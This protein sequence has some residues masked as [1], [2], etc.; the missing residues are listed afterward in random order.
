M[1]E[2]Q[3]RLAAKEI[4]QTTEHTMSLEKQDTSK[5]AQNL[6]IE[7]L[8]Q[9]MVSKEDKKIWRAKSENKKSTRRHST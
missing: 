4:V 6:L 8:A 9:E 1:L 3:A 5:E 2:D 7:E